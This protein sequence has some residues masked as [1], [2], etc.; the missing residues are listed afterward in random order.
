MCK[1]PPI[2]LAA[3]SAYGRAIDQQRSSEAGFHGLIVKPVDLDLRDAA[4][5]PASTASRTP[6]QDDSHAESESRTRSD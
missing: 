2:R 5:H 4:L 1:H 3:V 6:G